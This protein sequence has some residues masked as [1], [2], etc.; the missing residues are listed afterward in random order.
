MFELFQHSAE[1]WLVA[2]FTGLLVGPVAFY[3]AGP[4]TFRRDEI[5]Q[6]ISAS[7]AKRYFKTFYPAI[8]DQTPS[9]AKFYS[10]RFGRRRYVIPT[11]TLVATGVMAATWTT[12]SIL[13]WTG[14]RAESAGVLDRVSAAALS[15]AYLWVVADLI[16][17][18]RFRDLSPA[19]LW[20]SAW[21]IVV[22]TPLAFAVSAMLNPTFAVPAAFLL[23]AFPTRSISTLARR[24]ARRALNLGADVDEKSESEL[25]KLQGVDTRIAE[26]FADEGVTTIV[27]LAY[28][29]PVELTMRCAS[30]SFSFVI[31]CGSQ[32]LAWLYLGEN[33]EKLRTYSLRGA[34][35]IS[36]LVAELDGERADEK[37]V[38]RQTLLS[39]AAI[40]AVD[41]VAFERT[42]REIAADPYTEFMCDVWA[43]TD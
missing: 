30:F 6:G 17:R 22:A 36:S 11:L 40:V 35:E 2:L 42:L 34:Q 10:D 5:L 4:W 12:A 23:G 13:V 20:W 18:W 27:Q 43:V 8:S 16:A 14:L 7:A 32:A 15:G 33:L 19:D 38:A 3:L 9:F 25:E 29:D 31:D 28:S 26:R 37:A 1:P 41:P 21:R 39:A 24:F